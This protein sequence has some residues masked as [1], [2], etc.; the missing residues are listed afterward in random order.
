MSALTN[1]MNI[2]NNP[3][4]TK[5]YEKCLYSYNYPNCSVC[6]VR[7]GD[8]KSFYLSYDISTSNA[9]VTFNNVDYNVQ[10][11]EIYFPSLHYFNNSPTSGELII[12]HNGSNGTNL[13]V[14]IPIDIASGTPCPLLNNIFNEINSRQ[15]GKN[16]TIELSLDKEY[17]I[18]SFVKYAPYFYYLDNKINYVVY[19][20]TDG[21]LITQNI[22]TSMNN[23]LKDTISAPSLQYIS[24]LSYNDKG[25]YNSAGDEIYIDCQPVDSDGNLLI[26]KYN[27]DFYKNFNIG[28]SSS[29]VS[30]IVISVLVAIVLLFIIIKLFDLTSLFKGQINIF[31]I[32]SWGDSSS[33]S[34]SS[35]KSTQQSIIDATNPTTFVKPTRDL[36]TFLQKT[37]NK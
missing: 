33:S 14:C 1:S 26:D 5:C 28:S 8:S 27:K 10:H 3:P 7:I 24:N 11:I 31:K 22:L 2:T 15:L 17:T 4:A 12:Y 6:S 13:N 35:S 36:I 20:L 9:P 34:A 30:I 23:I 29:N 19:G 32:I 16:E 25:P 21:I 18:N 37:I